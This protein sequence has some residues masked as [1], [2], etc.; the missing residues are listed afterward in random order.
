M[1]EPSQLRAD[2]LGAEIEF[3]DSHT[4][5]EPTRIVIAG[6]P[7]LGRGTLADRRDLF[8]TRHDALR[9]AI[10]NEPRGSNVLVGGLLCEPHD[11]SCDAAVIFFNSAGFLGMCGHGTIGLVVTLGYLGRIS[12]GRIA[13]ETPV[14][15]VTATLHDT[16]RVT[17]ANVPA[18]R[19]R[20]N[21]ELEVDGYGRVVGDVAWGGNWFFL[22]KNS[23]ERV[24]LDNADALTQV[25]KKIE[26]ALAQQGVTGKEGARID[27]VELFGPG[28]S[29]GADSQ[30]YVLCPG[31]AFDR[32]PCGTGTSAKLACLAAEGRLQPG[33]IWRQAGIL[34]GIFETYYEPGPAGTIRPFLTGRAY[35]CSRGRLLLH[36]DDPFRFGIR[37]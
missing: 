22:V 28:D 17:I 3:L 33:Q 23:H 34:G 27:H 4:E 16:S 36:P 31:G 21:V 12:P 5:G 7:D 26:A 29:V 19:Y 10:V 8:R 37:S 30:N 11:P 35:P 1:K 6:G 14:G 13:I 32:S 25:T 9:S 2:E 18:F 20:S 15:I 24:A